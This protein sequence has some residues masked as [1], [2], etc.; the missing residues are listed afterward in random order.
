MTS[1]ILSYL[2]VTG[3]SDMDPVLK[4]GVLR[5]TVCLFATSFVIPSESLGFL[6]LDN[7]CFGL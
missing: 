7:L 1:F 5:L 2:L 4:C 3:E 6:F